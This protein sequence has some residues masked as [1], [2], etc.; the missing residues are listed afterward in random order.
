VTQGLTALVQHIQ[1]NQ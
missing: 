1:Q